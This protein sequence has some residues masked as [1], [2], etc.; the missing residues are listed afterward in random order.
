MLLWYKTL[1]FSLYIIP[2]TTPTIWGWSQRGGEGKDLAPATVCFGTNDCVR[3]TLSPWGFPQKKSKDVWLAHLQSGAWNKTHGVTRG[4]RAKQVLPVCLFALHHMKFSSALNGCFFFFFCSFI[5]F[6]CCLFAVYHRSDWNLTCQ[7]PQE[8][9]R[10]IWAH[11]PPQ[12]RSLKNKNHD[13]L[14]NN[15]KKK[16]C[17]H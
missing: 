8:L 7:I 14:K 9:L 15:K 6:L 11:A 5:F 3:C 1:T 2:K 10:W 12:G 4:L 13:R 17:N 16:S